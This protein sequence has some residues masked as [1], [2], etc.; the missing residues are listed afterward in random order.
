[1]VEC[2]ICYHHIENVELIQ[3]DCCNNS[4]YHRRCWLRWC[5]QSSRC[6]LCRAYQKNSDEDTLFIE[7]VK[8]SVE[9]L[10]DTI[11]RVTTTEINLGNVLIKSI[12]SRI[13]SNIKKINLYKDTDEFYLDINGYD[14]N[15]FTILHRIIIYGKCRILA[16]FLDK[17]GVFL[18]EKEAIRCNSTPLHLA[19]LYRKYRMVKLLLKYGANPEKRNFE[20]KDTVH[21]AFQNRCSDRMFKL[22]LNNI[23]APSLTYTS[24]SIQ[25]NRPK[26]LKLIKR[27]NGWGSQVTDSRQQL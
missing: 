2:I 24:Y 11:N 22:L 10:Y 9:A 3:L 21:I 6:A 25:Y 8:S 17:F 26:V 23:K 7:T 13:H 1:M 5:V 18:L 12:D 4:N 20:G 15:G 16:Y 19:V 14:R 27:E